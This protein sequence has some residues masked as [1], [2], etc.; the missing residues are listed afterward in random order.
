MWI[1]SHRRLCTKRSVIFISSSWLFSNSHPV[2]KNTKTFISKHSARTP[3]VSI[4][5][6]SH[7]RLYK[8]KRS[9]MIR[10]KFFLRSQW[11]YFC[12]FERWLFFI[13]QVAAC[14]ESSQPLSRLDLLASM[15]LYNVARLFW[16]WRS[17]NVVYWNMSDIVDVLV[18][19]IAS[20]CWISVINFDR[21]KVRSAS[22]VKDFTYMGLHCN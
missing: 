8:S 21:S 5:S 18:S 7:T 2:C 9:N 12:M 14:N 15:Y 13:Q 3:A 1:S 4:F 19:K 17:S 6:V 11:F 20:L 10:K 16:F 22:P